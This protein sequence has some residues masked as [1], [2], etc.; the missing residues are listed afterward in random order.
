MMKVL[1]W[2]SRGLGHPSK[3]IALRDLL[4]NERPEILLIKETKQ[5]QYEMQKIIDTQRQYSGA[6]SSSRGASGGIVTM[7]N[8]QQCDCDST[9][10]NQ[11]WIR[12]NLNSKE[13]SRDLIIYN[14]YIPN[15]SREKELCWKELKESIDSEQTS[16]IIIA[17]DFNLILHANEKRGGNFM[18]D[19]F[20]SQLEEIMQEHEMVDI[21]PKNRKYT[22]SNRR[23]GAGNIMEH[24]DRFLV[25][26]TL[27][28]SFAVGH[29][30]ILSSSASDHY[31]NL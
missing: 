25:N 21:I 4:Y 14:V 22:W 27:L 28:S 11:N 19:P 2:N 1:S 10:I 31:P 5:N 12:T 3:T 29:T 8:N 30:N 9:I 20:R 18:H 16:N 24:L 23:L 17:G 7:W 13:E 26:I 15:H 6:I